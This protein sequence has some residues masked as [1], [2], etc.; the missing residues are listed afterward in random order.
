MG[1]CL[2]VA[3]DLAA[4]RIVSHEGLEGTTERHRLDLAP[5]PMSPCAQPLA[6]LDRL[7]DLTGVILEMDRGWPGQSHLRL[8]A[9]VLRRGRRAWLLIMPDAEATAAE[10]RVRAGVGRTCRRVSSR[11]APAAAGWDPE[12]RPVAP[13]RR[14]SGG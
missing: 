2:Y 6:E 8:A 11:R 5:A 13:A 12:A 3:P 1:S 9:K 10:R 4:A 14:R 7:P